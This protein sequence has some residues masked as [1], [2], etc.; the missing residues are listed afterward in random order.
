[1]TSWYK[2][3]KYLV[4]DSVPVELQWIFLWTE[5][6]V[7]HS[8]WNWCFGVSHF[9]LGRFMVMQLNSLCTHGLLLQ[10][11]V[12]EQLAFIVTNHVLLSSSVVWWLYILTFQHSSKVWGRGQGCC[13]Y[14]R[15]ILT[16]LESFENN[17]PS[18]LKIWYRPEKYDLPTECF[19]WLGVC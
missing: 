10:G 16:H 19:V 12:A 13:P 4:S 1:M 17:I 7:L 6:L 18:S 3:V 2:N 8:C 14:P 15:K 5:L 11:E 9:H